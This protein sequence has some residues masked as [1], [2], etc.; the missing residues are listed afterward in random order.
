MRSPRRPARQTMLAADALCDTLEGGRRE[1]DDAGIDG[2][3]AKLR[4]RFA[5][6]LQG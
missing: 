4:Y 6:D 3:I 5:R 1:P 2:L